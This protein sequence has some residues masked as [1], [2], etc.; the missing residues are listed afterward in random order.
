MTVAENIYLGR[1]PKRAGLVI[2]YRALFER[3]RALFARL[4][5]DID[6]RLLMGRL[7]LVQTQLV[8]IAKAL[9]RH[10]EIIIMDEPTSAIGES[11]TAILF[12]AIGRVTAQ[13]AGVLYVSHRLSEIFTIA[14][15][16]TVLR[17]GSFV[18]ARRIADIDRRQLVRLIVGEDLRSL[19]TKRK[20]VAAGQALLSVSGLSRPAKCS[21]S[22][23]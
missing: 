6:P 20:T 17:D 16:Y 19:D 1:E 14:D 22:T 23:A 13:G 2:D 11:E 3:A 5:F 15:S 12:Q 10:S 9:S 8:E 7:S 18:Q 4:H 21:A